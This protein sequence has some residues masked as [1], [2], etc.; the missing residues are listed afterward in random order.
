MSRM[1]LPSGR[2]ARA[3]SR[4][5]SLVEFALIS[6][7]LFF[8]LL[9]I[10]EFARLL[11]IYS[12]VSNAAQEGSRYGIV[13]PRDVISAPAATQT[14]QAG[15]TPYIPKQVVAAGGCNVIDK[16]LDK[17]YSIDRSAVNVSVWYDNGS[18]TPIV[19]T[20]S[21]PAP[22]DTQ[23]MVKGNRINV[24]VTYNFN[25]LSPV[26]SA[27]VPGGINVKMR[28]ARTILNNGDN[29]QIPCQV[30]STP[31]PIPTTPVP[32]AT[33]TDLPIPTAI[34][35]LA[36][37]ATATSTG[38]PQPSST[39]TTS[40]TP[41]STPTAPTATSTGTPT[42]TPTLPPGAP[43]YTPGPTNTSTLT[44][45]NT[46]TATPTDTATPT[47]T[48]TVS[49]TPTRMALHITLIDAR[50]KP[51]NGSVLYVLVQVT[52]DGGAPFPSAIVVASAHIN[53]NPIPYVVATLPWQYA[54]VYQGCPVGQYNNGD[55]VTVDI[56]A[57]APGYIGDSV[58]GYQVISGNLLCH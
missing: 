28:S 44:P 10:I 5:Q 17:V 8:L 50:K 9:G 40:I 31:A 48:Y 35:T 1:S 29:S 32:S 26:M 52:D 33:A 2:N 21:T 37:S 39:P 58:T 51:Q 22:Y 11:F 53:G 15:G 19:P 4:G 25:F 12:V 49:P 41:T 14:A 45:T 16:T 36:P 57:D 42:S 27:L 24:E 6:G 20:T 3:S 18:G 23:A 34:P 55:N 43:T 56:T 38:V 54:G 13:R 47:A 46:S 7:F 30:N